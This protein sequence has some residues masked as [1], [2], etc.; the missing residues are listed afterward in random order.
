M[1]HHHLLRELRIALLC[2]GLSMDSKSDSP[3]GEEGRVE[4]V[5]VVV[6]FF[7]RPP[8]RDTVSLGSP[9]QPKEAACRAAPFAEVT[10]K[11]AQTRCGSVSICLSDF[12]R[13]FPSR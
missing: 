1:Q 13:Q 11:L 4:T 6:F 10:G 9:R 12:S 2:L 5:A 8:G 3:S 7:C